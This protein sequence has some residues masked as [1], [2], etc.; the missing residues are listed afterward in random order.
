MDQQL[1][2]AEDSINLPNQEL[3]QQLNDLKN[4]KISY[5]YKD[6]LSA[7]EE[8]IVVIQDDEIIYTNEIFQD[9]LH[10]LKNQ[11]PNKNIMDYQMFKIHKKLDVTSINEF[12]ASF[13]AVS[14]CQ[15]TKNE[16]KENL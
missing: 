2:E 8:G 5:E 4:K 1:Q 13:S 12:S 9:I 6:M 11:G 16:T 3:I 15:L 7:L 10:S 14:K